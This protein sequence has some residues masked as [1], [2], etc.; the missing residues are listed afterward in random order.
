MASEQPVSL[1]GAV[2]MEFELK[3]DGNPADAM[4]PLIYPFGNHVQAGSPI[5][6]RRENG[7]TIGSSLKVSPPKGV[8][9]FQIALSGKP[10]KLIYQER[11]IR[12]LWGGKFQ[13][14]SIRSLDRAACGTRKL[15]SNLDCKSTQLIYHKRG[16]VTGSKG[17]AHAVQIFRN[18]DRTG[19]RALPELHQW[20]Q[21]QIT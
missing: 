2:G 18:S 4:Y 19:F 8:E 17:A 7:R 10:E 16:I 11:N 14:D 9:R 6:S 13:A 15:L 5:R 21:A 1:R 12:F 3:V 20:N